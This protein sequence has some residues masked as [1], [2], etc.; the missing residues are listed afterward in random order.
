M[1]ITTEV[2]KKKKYK[3]VYRK[4]RGIKNVR[5]A[6]HQDRAEDNKVQPNEERIL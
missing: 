3:V 2:R 5:K 1:E 4:N 6:V